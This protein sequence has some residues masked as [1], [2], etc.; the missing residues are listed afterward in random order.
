MEKSHPPFGWLFSCATYVK[1]L[2]QQRFA[3]QLIAAR[4]VI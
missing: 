4:I 3:K 2:N 1:M